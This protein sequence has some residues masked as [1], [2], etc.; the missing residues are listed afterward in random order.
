MVIFQS[1]EIC[2]RRLETKDAELLIK[3]LSDPTVLKYYEGR[4]RAHDIELVQ[5]HFFENR[6]EIT[7]C[8]IQYQSVDIGYIQFYLINDEEVEKYGF[9]EFSG[10]IYGM[11]QFI[12][13]PSFWNRGIGTQL[14]NETVRY[15]ID[16]KEAKKV[17][18]D[19]QAWNTRALKVYEKCGFVKTKYLEK[20]EYHEGQYRDCWL[21]EYAVK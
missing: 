16:Q 6:D 17:V 1:N 10:K 9:S 21:I 14:I 8:I 15:L 20:H 11:D 2:I 12:G 7:Q 3:W 19:P 4:D 5:E 18:M 13:E